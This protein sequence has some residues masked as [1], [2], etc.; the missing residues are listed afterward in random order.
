MA[1]FRLGVVGLGHRGIHMFELATTAFPETLQGVAICDNNEEILK[2]TVEKFPN[3]TPYNDFY[4]ML[5]K[6]ELDVLLVETPAHC[7]AAFCVEGRKRGLF[8]FGEIPCVATLEEADALWL[9]DANAPKGFFMTGANPNEWGFVEALYSYY[10]QGLLGKPY[11]MEAEYI[12]DCR[13]LWASTPW[14]R[15]MYPITY[16]THSLGPLLRITDEDLRQ[17]S[18]MDTGAWVEGG[19]NEHDLMTAHFHA[20]SGLVVRFTAS[21]INNAGCGHHS[22]RVYGTEGYFER[23]SSRGQQKPITTFNS[24]KLYGFDK[25]SI[26]SI[27]EQRP[28]FEARSKNF[29]GHGGADFVLWYKFAQAL[30]ENGPAPISL[31]AGLRMTI[32]GIF[33]RESAKQGGKLVDITYPW[34]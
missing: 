25:S 11:Y 32:P 12:H 21:F 6:A 30:K 15:T 4:E 24:K 17:V 8:V 1:P 23:L 33:A 5:D 29:G 10:K 27:E 20:P 13:Y 2:A 26:I 31:K 14:R 18:C 3:A 19:E 28:E 16:C 22:Y 9:A 34:D 7:H